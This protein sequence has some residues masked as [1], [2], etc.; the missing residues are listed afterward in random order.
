MQAQLETCLLM[1]RQAS[2]RWHMQWFPF[3]HNVHCLPLARAQQV[4]AGA[5]SRVSIRQQ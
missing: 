3:A 5:R 2:T 4:G 1:L